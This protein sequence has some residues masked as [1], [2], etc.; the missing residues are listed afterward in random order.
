MKI[1]LQIVI[2]QPAALV[3]DQIA[4][5]RNEARWNSTLTDYALVGSEPIGQGSQFTYKNR[6]NEFHSTLAEYNKPASLVFEVTG[7]PMDITA[8]VTLTVETATTTV[9]DAVYEL[10]P[11]GGTKFA[12]LLFAPFLGK[13]FAK[14]FENFKRFSESQH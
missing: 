3:F 5:A 1:P 14:E 13:A 10:R 9:V 2:N 7:K 12:M 4:D 11:K 8:R 6:G